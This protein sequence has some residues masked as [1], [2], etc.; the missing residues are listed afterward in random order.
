[1]QLKL[2]AIVGLLIA[3]SLPTA[4]MAGST[5]SDTGYGVDP[6]YQQCSS[7][8]SSVKP[9]SEAQRVFKNCMNYCQKK[10]RISCGNG[11]YVDSNRFCPG[12][13]LRAF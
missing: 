12:N 2:W 13:R 8:L 3:S 1:M 9:R 11:V 7:T 10:G 5:T 6:C 4:A